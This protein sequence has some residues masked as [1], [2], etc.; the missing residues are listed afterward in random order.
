MPNP[1]G[2]LMA[3]F[4]E[5]EDLLAAAKR[6]RA[7]GYLKLN[8]HTPFHV[9]GLV[10]E[11]GTRDDRVPKVVFLFAMIG[12][13]TGF[14]MQTFACLVGYPLNI[15]GRPDYSWPS[16]IPI[17]FEMAILFAA[18]A[19]VFGMLAMN[20]L[21]RF[22][23]PVFSVPGFERVTDDKFFLSVSAADPRFQLEETRKLLVEIG[24]EAVQEVPAE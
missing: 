21:P 5:A 19:A 11:L 18:F 13:A 15:G 12:A 3:Q 20:D 2:G 7:N 4:S 1:I 22:Y 10:D 16:Y 9:E 23:H 8:A 14:G 6:M 24:A 17:T